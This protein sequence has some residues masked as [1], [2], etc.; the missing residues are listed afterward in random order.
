MKKVLLWTAVISAILIAAI[1]LAG[2]G[3]QKP[4]LDY[5]RPVFT[6]GDAIVC[7]LGLLLDPR[8]DHGPD[9][10]FDLFTSVSN[11]KEKEE[12]LGCT[13]WSGGIRVEAVRMHPPFDHYV[14]INATLFTMEGHL[15]NDQEATH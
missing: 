13:E 14:Q 2:P 3:P 1:Y 10:V 5:S 4:P 15:T 9:A 8:A 11:L 7:P 6:D 12:K